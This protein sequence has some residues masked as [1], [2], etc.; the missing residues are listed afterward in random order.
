[1]I[2]DASQ[3]GMSRCMASGHQTRHNGVQ[4]NLGLVEGDA[5]RLHGVVH[6]QYLIGTDWPRPKRREGDLQKARTGFTKCLCQRRDS[7]LAAQH[8]PMARAPI[9]PPILRNVG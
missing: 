2:S 6:V 9:R 8:M 4:A 5:R 1:M 7:A 3:I